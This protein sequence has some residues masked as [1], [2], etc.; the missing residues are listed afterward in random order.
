MAIEKNVSELK[1]GMILSSTVKDNNERVLLNEG[2]VIT[3]ANIFE[4]VR[5]KI[6]KVFVTEESV[7]AVEKAE[8]EKSPEMI[9]QEIF[10]QIVNTINWEPENKFE[11][12][13]FEMA[14]QHRLQ[15]KDS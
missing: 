15:K 4:L 12:D 7:L 8:N 10:D 2:S 3:D 14:V 11:K 1:V 5:N 9:R 13:L 6:F